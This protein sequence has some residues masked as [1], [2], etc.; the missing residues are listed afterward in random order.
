M[1]R[2]LKVILL[3]AGLC[4]LPSLCFSAVVYDNSTPN[5]T[6]YHPTTLEVGD[7]ITLSG[8]ERTL[9]VFSFEYFFSGTTV[10]T[11]NWTLRLYANNGIT[12][13]P[14]TVLFTGTPQQV[15]LGTNGYSRYDVD[16]GTATNL[17]T[18]PD[19]FTW[20]V[21]F[22]NLAAGQNA[23]LLVYGPPSIGT[24]FNDFWQNDG[25]GNWSLNVI[26][27]APRSDFIA[28]VTAVPEPG[29]LALGGLGVLLLAGLRRFHKAH[30]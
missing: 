7:Q 27:G 8:T 3:S 9:S 21:Q 6:G 28:T 18:L 17:I 26:N 19:T 29:V 4:S 11:Q 15:S 25:S 14:G 5:L 23:G 30:G 1:N 13:S 16:F 10:S 22:S 12:N 24:S 20:T 2:T